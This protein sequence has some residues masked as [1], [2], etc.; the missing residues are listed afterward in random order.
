VLGGA[1]IFGGEGRVLGTFLGVFILAVIENGLIMAR[2]SSY[3]HQVVVGVVIL[4]AVSM[5]V[6]KAK[7]Q[8]HEYAVIDVCMDDKKFKV[9]GGGR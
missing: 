3:G 9:E 2:V 5:D 1:N 7:R 8:E 4:V 6:M